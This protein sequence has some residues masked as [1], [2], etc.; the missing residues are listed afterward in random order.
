[1]IDQNLIYSSR[2]SNKAVVNLSKVTS[3]VLHHDFKPSEKEYTIV[4]YSIDEDRT[5]W[6][7]SCEELRDA[8][9]NQLLATY[10]KDITQ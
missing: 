5:Y 9:Y 2:S 4:F 10:C 8:D 7:Y 3:I 6:R 1:M